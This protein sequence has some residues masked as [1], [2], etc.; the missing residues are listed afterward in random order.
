MTPQLKWPHLW[1]TAML[2]VVYLASGAAQTGGQ[3]FSKEKIAG[4]IDIS[5]ASNVLKDVLI[6]RTLEWNELVTRVVLS[7]KNPLLPASF[8]KAS[9]TTAEATRKMRYLYPEDDLRTD[10]NTCAVVGNAGMMLAV[11]YGRDIDAHD[12]VIRLNDGPTANWTQWVGSKTTI[13]ILNNYWTKRYKWTRPKG[14]NEDNLM[15]FSFSTLGYLATIKRR[16]QSASKAVLFMAPELA[17]NAR[18]AYTKAYELL[19]AR[20]LIKVYGRNTAPTGI[21][22]VYMALMMCKHTNIYGFD[23]NHMDGFP[24][25]YFDAFKGTGSAHSFKFQSLFLKMLERRN[26]LSLCVPGHE[27]KWCSLASCPTC[28][29]EETQL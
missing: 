16:F 3:K 18:R 5:K 11:E 8:P 7:K 1:G 20:N 22:G 14:A 2:L 4:R 24:Y 28:M 9:Y 25:H 27:S 29:D 13:R 15:L 26:H 12:V 10:Y 17:M 6:P 23:V 21:E 19:K